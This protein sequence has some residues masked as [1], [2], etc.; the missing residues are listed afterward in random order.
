MRALKFLVILM[1]VLLVAGMATIVVIIVQRVATLDQ[2]VAAAPGFDRASV[3]LPPGASVLGTSAVDGRLVVRVGLA[4]G[5]D[6]LILIDPQSGK[7]LGTIELKPTAG[8][9]PK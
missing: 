6:E 4:G 3:E 8:E 5:G 9:E 2:R 7:R 1:G